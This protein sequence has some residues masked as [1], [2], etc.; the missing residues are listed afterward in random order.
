LQ[1][2]YE[3]VDSVPVVTDVMSHANLWDDHGPGPVLLASLRE[4]GMRRS[5]KISVTVL[6]PALVLVVATSVYGQTLTVLHSFTGG[7]D[8]ARPQ[9]GLTFDRGGNLYGTTHGGGFGSGTVFRLT[10]HGSSWTLSPLHSFNRTDGYGPQSSLIFGP[11]GA[12]YG[13]TSGGGQHGDGTV[14]VLRPPQTVCKTVSCPWTETLLYSFTGG[15][16]S[17]DPEGALVFDSSGNLYGVAYGDNFPGAHGP[18][19]YGNGSVWELVHA[20]GAWTFNLVYGFTGLQ[21][22]GEGPAGGVVF[23]SAGNLYGTTIYGGEYGEGTVFQLIPSGAGWTEQTLH[24]FQSQGIFPQAGLTVDSSGDMYG[25]TFVGGYAFELTP[26]GGNWSFATIYQV[27]SGDGPAA[28]LTIDAQGN[29]YGANQTGGAH[30]QGNVF[31]LVLRGGGWSYSDLYDFTG[32]SDGG[33]P[34]GSVVIDASGNIY[35]TALTGGAN[36]YGTVWKLTP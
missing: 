8:G 17:M 32:G 10:R 5:D 22:D 13:T 20:G 3:D 25:V 12:L 21:G 15:E 7:N 29:L 2:I 24:S 28:N 34:V 14:F 18:Q 35:G 27:S 11:D 6:V 31:K 16:D 19:G 26:S 4:D 9:T 30:Q 33:Q 36:S 23:D 1:V